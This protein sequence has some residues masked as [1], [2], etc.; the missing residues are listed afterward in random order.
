MDLSGKF[1]SHYTVAAD[2]DQP[3]RPL[4]DAAAALGLKLTHIVL[5]CGVHPS[6]PMLTRHGSG[7]LSDELDKARQATH[8]LA[9]RGWVVNRVK[10][11]ASIDNEHVPN[12]DEVANSMDRICHFEHHIKLILGA[13]VDLQAI[14]DRVHPCHAHVSRNALRTRTDGRQERFITQRCYGV[15][16]NSAGLQLQE[17]LN[18]LKL[19]EYEIVGVEREYVAYDSNVSLDA[20]WIE[21]SQG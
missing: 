3:I 20:G 2:H 21:G 13:S 12:S 4:Q 6:Q 14:I 8:A 9:E 15:G 1:E 19:A 17:L 5:H 10:I 7:S 11:E 16:S 18:R